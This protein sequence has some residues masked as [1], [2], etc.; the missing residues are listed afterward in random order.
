MAI[1]F[2]LHSAQ[3]AMIL[4][5]SQAT[6]SPG[7]VIQLPEGTYSRIAPRSAMAFCQ[8]IHV[9]AGVID[10]DFAGLIECLLFN[11]GRYPVRISTGDH[12]A[13]LFCERLSYPK[14]KEIEG[15]ITPFD[16]NPQG[17]GSSSK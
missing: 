7:L 5:W 10:A 15:A 16:R 9:T 4:P 12:I 14:P 6:I 3:H 17:F 2:D 13:Q 8:S 11:L 1:G